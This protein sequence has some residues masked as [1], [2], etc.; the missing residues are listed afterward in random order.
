M[1]SIFP[2]LILLLLIAGGIWLQIFLSKQESKWPGLILPMFTFLLSLVFFFLSV[3]DNPTERWSEQ[4][5]WEITV[6]EDGT[7]TYTEIEVPP[8][9]VVIHTT[10][11][12]F[13]FILLTANIPT[14][15]LLA[16]YAV[17]RRKQSRQRSLDKMSVQDLE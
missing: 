14:A 3:S 5:A 10:P 17:C 8:S 15:I 7:R 4:R 12:G 16:I 9:P 6:A 1:F 13:V 2:M 11:F